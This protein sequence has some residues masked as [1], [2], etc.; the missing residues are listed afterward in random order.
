MKMQSIEDLMFTGM[1]YTL[2]FEQRMTAQAGKMAE[3]ASDPQVKDIFEK[4]TTQ[5]SKYAE[6]IEQIFPKLGR[7]KDTNKNQ[8]AIAMID[9]VENM[10][11][12]TDAGP[13]R[14]AALIVAFN[15]QQAYRVANY[16]SLRSYAG[17]LGKQDAVSDLQLSV[18][19]SKAGDDKL[20]QIAEQSVNIKAREVQTVAA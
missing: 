13:V 20:T 14:D 7:E 3:A 9:E 15:Q 6:R 4:T 10:I 17:L 8:V 5:G 16:G 2:D 11:S 12:N 1:T 18:E 19:E